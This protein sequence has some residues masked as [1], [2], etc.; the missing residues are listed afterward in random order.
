M[1]KSRLLS[2]I[3]LLALVPTACMRRAEREAPLPEPPITVMVYNI[4]AGKDAKGVDNLADVA[5]LMRGVGADI[6]LLQ[7]VDRGT[8]RSGY[9]D[10][11]AHLHR[12]TG[13]SFTFGRSLDYQG[14]Q[15]GIATM[16]RWPILKEHLIPLT[17][18][19][20]QERAGGSR[21]PR[22]GLAV[23]VDARGGPITVINTHIDA[24][25][26]EQWR[27][28][29]IQTLLAFADSIRSAGGVVLMGGDF[30]S[31]PESAVQERIRS[32]GG[33]DA[34]P[35]CGTGG[36]NTFPAD[37]PVKRIDYLFH[38]GSFECVE[39]RVIVS[40]AS[41]H[42]P[43]LVRLRRVDAGASPQQ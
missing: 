25:A 2:T 35:A 16:S 31:T 15:Y 39:A 5:A 19:P 20:P 13:L 8:Q 42:R 11:P 6:V 36:E 21:E 26:N 43:L 34:W 1:T 10:Q 37:A 12:M 18:T 33:K 24:S 3:L 32:K 41:D 28:Q 9:I 4:H 30:N 38:E 22:V 29:E 40:E 23:T 27:L 7:E 14:G 17:V